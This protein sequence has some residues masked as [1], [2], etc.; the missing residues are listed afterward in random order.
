MTTP[1]TLNPD[2]AELKARAKRVK[3]LYKIYRIR[4]G[5]LIG[6]QLNQEMRELE[7]ILER[8][9]KPETT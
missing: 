7:A 4:K 3:D 2:V 5:G 6:A 1:V 9:E 8:F